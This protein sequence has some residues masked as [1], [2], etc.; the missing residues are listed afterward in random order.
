M[1]LT[2]FGKLKMENGKLVHLNKGDAQIYELFKKQLPEGTIID[3][4]QEIASDDGTL[5][6]LAKIHT[7]IREL[8]LHTGF[9]FEEVKLLIKKRSG[10]VMTIKN[11]GKE[12]LFIKSLGDCNKEELSIAIQA[13]LELGEAVNH[14]LQ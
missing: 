8:S 2:H 9:T 14:P 7:M 10:L 12:E 6:Q 13:A 11:D 1:K 3:F 4:Y 5:A